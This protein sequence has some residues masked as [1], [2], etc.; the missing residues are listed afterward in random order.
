[1]AFSPRALETHFWPPEGEQ[2]KR[3]LRKSRKPGLP[4]YPGAPGCGRGGAIHHRTQVPE[5]ERQ[6]NGKDTLLLF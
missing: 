5:A 1:M 3:G 2:G 6:K 4:A